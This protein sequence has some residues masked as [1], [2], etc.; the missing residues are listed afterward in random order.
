MIFE[1]L[2]HHRQNLER[3][4]DLMLQPEE[5]VGF[6]MQDYLKLPNGSIPED[7]SEYDVQVS[8]SRL[9]HLN[10]N[11]P[12][13]G[14]AACALGHSVCFLEPLGHAEKFE[15]YAS[16]VYGAGKVA[17]DGGDSPGLRW[18]WL[19]SP[20]WTVFDN[21]RDGAARRIQWILDGRDVPSDPFDRKTLLEIGYLSEHTDAGQ[22]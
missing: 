5:R 21:T 12:P 17:V 20:A 22:A 1:I 10:P 19:F 11:H 7:L 2:P 3:L 9:I 16:R 13:C 8:M 15:P 4:R 18:D 6:H 14:T